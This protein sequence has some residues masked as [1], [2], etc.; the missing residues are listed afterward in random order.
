MFAEA[1]H[2]REAIVVAI[3]QKMEQ[4]VIES[5]YLIIVKAI[6]EEDPNKGLLGLLLK[7]K[8]R[9]KLLDIPR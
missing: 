5:D 7:I 3:Q 9:L 8:F 6:N 4:I 2:I 1:L